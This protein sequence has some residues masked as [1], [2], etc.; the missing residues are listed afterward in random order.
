MTTTN[1]DT[2]TGSLAH[3]RDAYKDLNAAKLNRRQIEVLGAMRQMRATGITRFHYI[4]VYNAMAHDG[5]DIMPQTV[6]S[7]IGE[8]CTA[9]KLREIPGAKD[10]GGRR[11]RIVEL[12]ARQVE[13]PA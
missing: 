6:C 4:D 13:M 2:Q 1:L 8:L 12:V 3:S 9:G 10:P 11:G 5:I 7:R